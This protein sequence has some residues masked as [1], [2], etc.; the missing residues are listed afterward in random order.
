MQ[1]LPD[2]TIDEIKN[3]INCYVSLDIFAKNKRVSESDQIFS[4]IDTNDTA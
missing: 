1:A 2:I 4:E 3:I